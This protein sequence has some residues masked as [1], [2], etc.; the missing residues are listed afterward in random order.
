MAGKWT[1]DRES[2]VQRPNHYTTDPH[3]KNPET[4]MKHLNNLILEFISV[5][6][7]MSEPL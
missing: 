6:F 2:Q 7:H 1:C 4:T 3:A 5:L